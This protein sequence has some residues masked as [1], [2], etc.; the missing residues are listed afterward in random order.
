MSQPLLYYSTNLKSP[1]VTFKEAMLKGLAPDGGLYMPDNIPAFRTDELSS[2]SGKEYHDRPPRSGS[3]V[4]K[5]PRQAAAS[6]RR[7]S[8]GRGSGPT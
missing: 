2:L 7:L 4:K 3:L 1:K 6:G 8:G 5:A